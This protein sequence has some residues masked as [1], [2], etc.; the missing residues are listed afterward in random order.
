MLRRQLLFFLWIGAV[1]FAVDAGTLSLLF[2]GF[3]LNLYISRIIAFIL[4]TLITW[5]LNRTYTFRTVGVPVAA[6]RAREYGLYMSVQFIGGLINIGIFSACIFIQPGWRNFPILPLAIGSGV[7]MLWNFTGS[8]F[9]IF[10]K[11]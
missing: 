6:D 5:S 3:G 11:T 9:W 7:G 8:R 4:A 1:G 10:R 2:S